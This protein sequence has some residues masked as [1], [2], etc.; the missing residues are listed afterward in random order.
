MPHLES[1]PSAEYPWVKLEETHHAPGD[2]VSY[3]G[4]DLARIVNALQMN[5]YQVR[6][7]FNFHTDAFCLDGTHGIKPVTTTPPAIA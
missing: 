5:G 1:R 2:V 3:H 4:R 7:G 6:E